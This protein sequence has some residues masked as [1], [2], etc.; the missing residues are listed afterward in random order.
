MDRFYV[1]YPRPPP[2]LPPDIYT[3]LLWHNERIDRLKGHWI[4]FGEEFYRQKACPRHHE[5][6]EKQEDDISMGGART[7]LYES[8]GSSDR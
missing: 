4:H 5:D 3:W 7:I 6:E 8:P 1:E 2:T